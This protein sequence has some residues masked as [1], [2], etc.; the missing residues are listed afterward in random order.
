LDHHSPAKTAAEITTEEYSVGRQSLKDKLQTFRPRFACYV[1]IGVYKQFAKVSAVNCGL[2]V[3]GTIENVKDF[4]VSSTS[5]LNRI[6]LD[7][8][9][10][11][12]IEL[13]QLISDI[14]L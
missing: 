6:P 1:G 8:Q 5:G 9:L 12:Y 14:H 4:V 7:K 3:K 2:Q 10:A 13:K 11:L